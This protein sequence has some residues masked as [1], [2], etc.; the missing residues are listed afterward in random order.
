MMQSG[1]GLSD[2]GELSWPSRFV[3]YISGRIFTAAVMDKA[4]A[5]RTTQKTEMEWVIVRPVGLL[6][7]PANQTGSEKL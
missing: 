6:D 5:E 1:I 7:R 4:A 2:G 3:V